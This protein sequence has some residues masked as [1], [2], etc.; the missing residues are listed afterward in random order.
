MPATRPISAASVLR[1]RGLRVSATRRALV[2]ALFAS[3]EPLSADQL[4]AGLDRAS[5]YRNLAQLEDAG[6]A[7]HLHA[8]SAA[9]RWEPAERPAGAYAVCESCSALTQLDAAAAE[10]IRA[11]AVAACGFAPDLSHHAL[12]GRCPA[13]AN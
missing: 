9:G 4:A 7:R 12:V 5:V 13:C 3:A 2:Q 1:S 10:C 6:L 11:A 8:G